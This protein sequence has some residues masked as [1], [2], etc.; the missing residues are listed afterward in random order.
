MELLEVDVNGSKQKVHMPHPWHTK[1]FLALNILDQSSPWKRAWPFIWTNKISITQKC[2]MLSLFDIEIVF[3]I[4]LLS[5]LGK[6]CSPSTNL[7]PHHSRMPFCAKYGW[8]LPSGYGE[9]NKDVKSLRHRQWQR[10][11]RTM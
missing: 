11:P 1:P 6:G 8:N 7:N 9:D 2:F 4:L 10:R 5:P 3:A